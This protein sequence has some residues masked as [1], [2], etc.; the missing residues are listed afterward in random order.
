MHKVASFVQ[1]CPDA[2]AADGEQSHI[3]TTMLFT[4][5]GMIER[6]LWG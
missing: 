5:L 3:E 4:K 6:L 2:P 1:I